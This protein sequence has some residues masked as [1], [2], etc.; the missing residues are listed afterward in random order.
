MNRI[1]SIIAFLLIAQT[2]WAQDYI[3][4]EGASALNNLL[5]DGPQAVIRVL[6]ETDEALNI[7]VKYEGFSGASEYI[8]RG[9]IL[10][11][12]KKPMKEFPAVKRTVGKGEGNIDLGFRL[13]LQSGKSYK[14][15]YLASQ[16]IG[17]FIYDAK[18]EDDLIEIPG[19]LPILFSG[20]SF[21]FKHDKQ[22]RVGGDESMVIKVNLTPTGKAK[23]IRN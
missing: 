12:K 16:F 6:S 19:S 18:E 9:Y 7:E 5:G 3:E 10:D 13:Q 11:G 17:V 14:D 1:C 4:P 8:L 20:S 23:T 22:W 15:A 2:S 21:N